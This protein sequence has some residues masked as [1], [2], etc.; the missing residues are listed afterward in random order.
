MCSSFSLWQ[1]FASVHAAVK[2]PTKIKISG[3]SELI[4]TNKKTKKISV[5]SQ[6]MA[7]QLITKPKE[8]MVVCKNRLIMRLKQST[9]L[10][11]QSIVTLKTIPMCLLWFSTRLK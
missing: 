7:T 5:S 9:F 11:G 2:T 3:L 10:K 8:E 6:I 4:G 1:L